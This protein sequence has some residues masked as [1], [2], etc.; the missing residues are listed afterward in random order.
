MRRTKTRKEVSGRM[1]YHWHLYIHLCHTP[2][3]VQRE[4]KSVIIFF[5][6]AHT[7]P[8]IIHINH[9][10]PHHKSHNGGKWLV[11]LPS[12]PSTHSLSVFLHHHHHYKCLRERWANAVDAMLFSLHTSFQSFALCSSNDGEGRRAM[13]SKPF[14]FFLHFSFWLLPL[15]LWFS[16]FLSSNSRWFLPQRNFFS[17]LTWRWIR[18]ISLL[19]CI[20]Q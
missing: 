9:S 15:T 10:T 8:H 11:P 3:F 19:A 13:K 2:Y 6:N 18:H 16:K 14:T 4:E 17:F 20:T 12:H 1:A 7:P 5:L